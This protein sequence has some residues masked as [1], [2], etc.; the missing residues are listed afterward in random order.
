MRPEHKVK[1]F[2]SYSRRKNGV[3]NETLSRLDIY[4]KK[5][6]SAFIHCLRSK[7]YYFEQFHVIYSLLQSDIVLLVNSP[8]TKKSPWVKLE[9]RLAKL[10]SKPILKI[11]S[12]DL[13][14]LLDSRE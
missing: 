1:I 9:L 7:K 13:D 6:Y 2:V 11:E 10:T 5:R 8:A 12:V 4:L 14:F 3:T